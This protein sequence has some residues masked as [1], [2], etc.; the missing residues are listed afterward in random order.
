MKKVLA[1]ALAI[2]LA[3]SAFYGYKQ[4]KRSELIE[5]VAPLV[6]NAS[7]RV[8]NSAKLATGNSSITFKEMF[9]RL[10]TDTAEIEKRSIDIES[11]STKET[12]DITTPAVA[13]MRDCQ[14]FSRALSMKYRKQLAFSNA[15]ESVE[16]AR[17]DLRTAGPYGFDY[18]KKRGDAAIEKMD[19]AAEEAKTAVIDFA[20]AAEKLKLSRTKLATVLP[21][22]ALVSLA[23]LQPLTLSGDKGDTEKTAKP[24]QAVLKQ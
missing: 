9:D 6:K 20:K 19:K 16:D 1:L 4:Y 22:D 8:T 5:T 7:I 14:E 3:A 12:A 23:Q 21:D 10:D 15:I 13:Y 24:E 17:H 11:M 18:A 2:A